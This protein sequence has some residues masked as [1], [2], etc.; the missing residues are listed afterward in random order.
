MLMGDAMTAASNAMQSGNYI[1]INGRRYPVVVDDGIHEASSGIHDPNGNLLP[2]E[3]ASSIY[4]VP[5]TIAGNFPVTYR[6]FLDYRLGGD[7]ANLLRGNATFWTDRGQ[8]SW[9]LEQIKWCYKLSLKTEQRVV[10]RTPQIAGRIDHVK[11]SP[12]QHLRSHDPDSPYWAD[13]GVSVRTGG[14][15]YAVWL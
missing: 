11:Y 12:L 10:L 8:Y 9:A 4:M 15:T 2:G 7:D 6:Q 5:L 13:G 1:D 3:Y 14:T